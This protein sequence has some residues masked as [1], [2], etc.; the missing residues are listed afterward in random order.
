MKII[1][2]IWNTLEGYC[3]KVAPE[4]RISS[5]AAGVASLLLKMWHKMSDVSRAENLYSKGGLG[6]E[7]FQNKLLLFV[8]GLNM[9]V[10]LH[11][12][13]TEEKCKK[14]KL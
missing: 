12:Y 5:A 4:D 13:S 7:F 14:K 10:S 1:R 9:C 3:N 11:Q 8:K 2:H 6:E